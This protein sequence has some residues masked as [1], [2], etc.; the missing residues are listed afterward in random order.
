[1]VPP[2]CTGESVGRGR[3]VPGGKE[4]DMTQ[5]EDRTTG[6]RVVVRFADDEILEGEIEGID[7]DEPDFELVVVE[8]DT[9]NRVALI[10]LHSVKR[11]CLRRRA[12]DG[13]DL[14]GLQK[15]A[16]RFR[17][18]EV[19]KGLLA[20]EPRHGRYGVHVELSGP[21]G[22]EVDELAVA[23]ANLK[24]VFYLKSWDSRPAEFANVTGS[25]IGRRCD[26]PLVELLGEIRRLSRLRDR[27]EL[28]GEEFQRRR[29]T[30]IDRI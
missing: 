27:G 15:V 16:L 6:T 19:V 20:G 10:P 23:Y 28:S 8:A 17:D 13:V 9:N 24:A 2:A 7:L 3:G 4:G 30:I 22:R 1:M 12:L 21:D 14:T 29:R 5:M 25:W 18:G 26:P 11:V